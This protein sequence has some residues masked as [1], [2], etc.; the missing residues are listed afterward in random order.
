MR[1]KNRN[2]TETSGDIDKE[3]MLIVLISKVIHLNEINFGETFEIWV[4]M[5]AKKTLKRVKLIEKLAGTNWGAGFNTLCTSAF[6]LCPCPLT[7][8]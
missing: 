2:I 3:K 7:P 5:V 1:F 4:K 6:A 8:T